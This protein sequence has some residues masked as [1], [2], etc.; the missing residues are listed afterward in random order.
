MGF[1]ALVYAAVTALLFSRLLPHLR[2]HVYSDL[3]DPLLNT[4]ILA[5]SA[6]HRPLTE[7][8]WNFPAFAPLSGV[9]AFTEHLLLTYPVASPVIWLTGNPVLAYNLVFLLA[10]PLNG[11]AA[12]ALARELLGRWSLGEGGTGSRGAA[13][14][15]GLAFAFAPYQSVH[16]SHVQHMTSFGMPLALLWLHRY[17]RTGR[18]SALVWFGAGWLITILSNSALLVFFPVLVLLWSVWFVRPHEWTRPSPPWRRRF[19]LC[20]C[21]GAI[22]YVRRRT[23]SRAHT[24]RFK[25]SA[26]TCR[27]CLACT[28]VPCRGTGSFRTISKRGRC[29]PG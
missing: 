3:G 17:F 2:T 11:M 1:A 16:L 13:L 21:C 29:F 22:T 18:R 20:R 10:P 14:V 12:F 7:A 15:A 25:A 27:A 5:W 4:S 6:A 26:P 23:A 28:T 9:T 24:R 8:W 19:P